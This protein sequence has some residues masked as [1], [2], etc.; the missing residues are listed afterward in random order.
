MVSKQGFTFGDSTNISKAK[1]HIGLYVDVNL[2]SN[3]EICYY[4][5]SRGEKV[6]VM[7]M[8]YEKTYGTEITINLETKTFTSK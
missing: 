7:N 1:S 5:N 4:L 6:E 3:T 2:T 8:F